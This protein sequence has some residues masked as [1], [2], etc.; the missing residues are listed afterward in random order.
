VKA[1]YLDGFLEVRITLDRDE[2]E[3]KKVLVQRA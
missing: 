2:I 1:T 3:A